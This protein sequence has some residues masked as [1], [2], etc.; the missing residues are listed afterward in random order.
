MD[1]KAISKLTT[2]TLWLVTSGVGVV[3]G[4]VPNPPFDPRPALVLLPPV[5]TVV[6]VLFR[7][8]S[9]RLEKEEFSTSDALAVGYL[10]NLLGP[11]ITAL[12]KS[13]EPG[14]PSPKVIVFIPDQLGQTD[15][16]SGEIVQA[17]IREKGFIPKNKQMDVSE[18]RPRN[19]LA[20]YQGDALYAY[21]DFPTTLQTLSA[22]VE[23]RSRK[24]G[25]SKKAKTELGKEFI[26]KFKKALEVGLAERL[27]ADYVWFTDNEHVPYALQ[28]A[29][30]G[31]PAAKRR[32]KL[33]PRR[34]V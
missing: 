6:T 18:G 5:S 8:Y 22:Y 15:P 25:L 23:F 24:E 32:F 1:I 16:E 2:A 28:R 33:F 30:A 4:L 7:E 29:A 12:V 27:L 21:F 34:G 9:H 20:L 17:N 11:I 26:G 10:T 31:Q 19:L 14:T 13:R 3:Q